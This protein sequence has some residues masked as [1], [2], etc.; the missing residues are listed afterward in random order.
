VERLRRLG[1]TVETLAAD[2]ARL[3]QAV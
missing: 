2:V 3:G 1:H